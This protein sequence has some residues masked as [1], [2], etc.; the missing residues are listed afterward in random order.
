MFETFW[1]QM[2]DVGSRL[3]SLSL[4]RGHVDDVQRPE[5]L[6]GPAVSNVD[7]TLFWKVRNQIEA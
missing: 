7:V 6:F 1:L 4:L 3:S 2:G 5:T